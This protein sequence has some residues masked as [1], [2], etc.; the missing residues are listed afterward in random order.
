MTVNISAQCFGWHLLHIPMNLQLIKNVLI[1]FDNLKNLN[2]H[3]H[4]CAHTYNPQL[5]TGVRKNSTHPHTP[6]QHWKTIV[7]KHLQTLKIQINGLI[8]LLFANE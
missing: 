8:F 5:W 4:T 6:M 7:K 3:T 1:I 2:I